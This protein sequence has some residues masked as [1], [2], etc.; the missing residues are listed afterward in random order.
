MATTTKLAAEPVPN[1]QQSSI[2][3]QI[4]FVLKASRP[5]FWSTAIWF[6]LLTVAQKPVLGTW[7]FWLGVIYF[8]LP[9]GLLLYGW[10]DYGDRATDRINPR[11]GNYLYGARGNDVELARLPILIALV[12]IPFLAAFSVLVGADRVMPWFAVLLLVNYLYNNP[13]FRFKSRPGLELLNQTGYLL[14]FVMGS[15]LNGVPQ[16][17][18]QTF[19]FGAVFAMQAHLFG[20][21]MDIEPDRIAGRR[22]TAILLGVQPS[23]VLMIL[24]LLFEAV[25]VWYYF[26]S[27][28]VTG[29]FALAALYFLLDLSLLV[30]GRFYKPW[31][32]QLFALGL[33]AVTLG[34][35]GWFWV[36]GSLSVLAR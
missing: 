27:T 4:A 7:A 36:T 32:L 29:F 18:W 15:W 16:L 34:S 5:G 2:S 22:T 8:S 21:I 26:R 6:Y 11:K 31:E 33:N 14:V 1:T 12:Q 17:P 25:L 28:I 19:V 9:F 30:R 24:F 3:Q 10:N 35:M 20:Q 13:P 23:K